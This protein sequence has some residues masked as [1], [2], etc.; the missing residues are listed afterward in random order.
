M[1]YSLA[2][3]VLSMHAQCRQALELQCYNIIVHSFVPK[4]IPSFSNVDQ[5]SYS[6]GHPLR[7]LLCI[8][9]H[10]SSYT[11]SMQLDKVSSHV[12]MSVL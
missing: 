9:S 6:L 4:P 5:A 1:S 2:S 7:A 8:L 3:K 11:L 10:S 12:E